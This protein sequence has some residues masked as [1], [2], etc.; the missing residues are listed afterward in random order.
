MELTKNQTQQ[1]KK[2]LDKKM[3]YYIDIRVEVLDHIISEI[4]STMLTEKD[5]DHS[6]NKATEKW[7]VLLQNSSSIYLGYCYVKPLLIINKMKKYGKPHAIKIWSIFILMLLS[8]GFNDS[9]S[10]NVSTLIT[11]IANITFQ[12][13]S[14]VISLL[15]ILGY[16]HIYSTKRKTSFRFLYETQVLAVVL[17]P[18]MIS[19]SFI[20]KHDG[21]DLLKTMI[22]VVSLF[23]FQ[24]A[25]KLY[26]KHFTLLKK[27]S[28]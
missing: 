14:Y 2:Y 11:D 16:V 23:M 18:F 28:F 24:L 10:L 15:I 27:Y 20:T 12:T 6:F 25:I 26:K 13:V 1:V 19:G 21:L 3:V 5:F 4:E 22:L 8:I 17:F 9:I 7:N